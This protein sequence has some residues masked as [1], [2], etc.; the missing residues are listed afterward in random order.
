MVDIGVMVFFVIKGL[1]VMVIYCLV[2]CGFL[3]Y[4]VLVVEYWFEFGVNGKFEVI[5]SDVL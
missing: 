3:F 1:V 5:V 4:D 2:D